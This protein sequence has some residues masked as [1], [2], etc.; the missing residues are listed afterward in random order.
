MSYVDGFV[1]VV[2]TANKEQY[3]AHIEIAAEMFKEFGGATGCG[4]LG[5]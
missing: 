1:A 3:M 4:S 5:K 2:P